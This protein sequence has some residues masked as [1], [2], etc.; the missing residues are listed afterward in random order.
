MERRQLSNGIRVVLEHMPSTRSVSFGI[1]VKT[2]SRNETE[3]QN[4][5]SHF[6]EHMLFKGT[7]RFTAREIAEVFDGIGGNINAFTSKE[8]TCYYAKVLDEHIPIA[9]DVLADMFFRSKLA[10]EELSK[11]KNVIIEE[12][13]MYEDTPDD[14]VHDLIAKAAF[15]NHAL[16]MPILG[17]EANL[18]E[19]TP[20]DLREFMNEQYGLDGIVLSAAGNIDE[21]LLELLEKH[22]GSLER[23]MNRPAAE[24]P[25]VTAGH[26]FLKKKTEQNH[27]CLAMP[28]LS[29]D[30]PLLYAMMLLNNCIGG[31]MS[32]RL[33][34]EVREERGL[35][36]SIYSYHSAYLDS[37]L[38]TIYAGTTPKQTA[39]V[40]ALIQ[41][42]IDDLKTN[43][44]TE[45][46]LHKGKEQMKGNLIL[47]LEST[48]SRM[49]RNGRNE[50][51][52]G[53][54]IPIDEM[55]EKIEAVTL[56]D[57]RTVASRM[58][59]GPY[60]TAMVG[61]SDKVLLKWREKHAAVV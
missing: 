46:E 25:V 13:S 53:R 42:V 30:D 33:F 39:E 20:D 57:I 14:I 56:E 2:G 49:S 52:H 28:G 38:F 11:E 6:I 54:Q 16:G 32:S 1:W 18:R 10:E 47:G 9:V 43:G 37:G 34:Q 29:Q 22:F 51:L 60:A 4:G 19:M 27:I 5:I 59:S 58:F 55:I 23:K 15:G 12:I 3:Q 61:S 35:A 31:G 24:P 17:T 50:L 40:L 21:S 7:D 36:Y 26:E 41:A 48:G 8:Y 44:M 45:N